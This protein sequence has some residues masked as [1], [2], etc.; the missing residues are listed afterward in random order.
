MP[1]RKARPRAKASSRAKRTLRAK[2]SRKKD[3]NLVVIWLR[4]LLTVIVVVG[5][6]A[7]ALI[8]IFW[9]LGPRLFQ[10]KH[11]VNVVFVNPSL[12]EGQ[13]KIYLISFSPASAKITVSPVANEKINVIGGYGE[14]QL[15]AVY[16]LL[17]IERKNSH[18]IKAGFGWGL[19]EV[20]DQVVVNHQLVQLDT[21]RELLRQLKR[22]LWAKGMKWQTLADTT[23]LYF[24][25]RAL[26][27]ENYVFSEA[28]RPTRVEESW[29]DSDAEECNIAIVNTTGVSG[30]ATKMSQILE[31]SG[32]RVV[33]I[34]DQTSA[35]QLSSLN[36]A[37]ENQTCRQFGQRIQHL[38]LDQ[39]LVVDNDQE[40]QAHRADLVI[41]I[42][43]DL[44]EL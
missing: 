3:P 20:V 33:R 23:R 30:M 19:N 36:Y 32:G 4:K 41:F 5:I 37:P 1:R 7:A 34:A 42:G 35:H 39:A 31:N 25:A 21:K 26:P 43:K 16:P 40:R 24:F 22:E 14:Y 10:L 12:D 44:T 13:G 29:F 6:T 17:E 28:V 2:P 15:A 38:F 27:L 9:V 18:F 8:G 11:D